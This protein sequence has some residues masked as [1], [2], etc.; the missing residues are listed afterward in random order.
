MATLKLKVAR[1]AVVMKVAAVCLHLVVA[2]TVVEPEKSK[3]IEN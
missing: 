3:L 1:Q 2:K